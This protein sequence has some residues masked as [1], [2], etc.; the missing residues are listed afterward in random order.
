MKRDYVEL[1]QKITYAEPRQ[2]FEQ[3][4]INRINKIQ[5]RKLFI[6]EMFYA[7]ISIISF[8]GVISSVVYT[9]KALSTSGV[10]QYIFAIIY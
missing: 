10:Y 8:V 7:F 6:K 4:I 1:F 2:G 9:L 3:S 5:E